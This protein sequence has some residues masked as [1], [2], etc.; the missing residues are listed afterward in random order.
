MRTLSAAVLCLV[1]LALSAQP[2]LILTNGK[3]FDNPNAQAIA[4]TG[5]TITAVGTNAEIQALATPATRTIDVKGRLVI[6]GINDAHTHP[7]TY[8][9]SFVANSNMEATWAQV[10]AAISSAADETPAELWITATAGPS[11]ITDAHITNQT[12]DKLAPGRK[13]FVGSWTGHGAILSSAALTALGIEAGV[14]NPQG[15]AFGRDAQ[16]KLNGRVTEYANY[17]ID[18]RFADLASDEEMIAGIRA[19]SDEAIRYGV[20]SVQAM[21]MASNAR[22]AKLLRT[23]NVPLRVRLIT[24]PMMDETRPTV[25]RG[26]AVKFILDGTPV[27]RGAALRTAQYPDSTRGSENF[28][29]LAPFVKL[30]ADNDAQLLFHTAGDKTVASALRA[31]QNTTLKRPRLEH[32]DGLQPDLFPLA[33]KSGAVV[34]INP[35]HFPA[36]GTYPAGK[37][38]LAKSLADAKIPL[39]IGSDGPMNPGLNIMLAS[40]RP[41]TPDE[42]L[43]REQV[44]RAY[45]SGSAFAENMETK[46]GKIAPGMLADIAVLSQDILDVQPEMLPETRSVLT[47]IDGK[48]VWEER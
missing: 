19:F 33:Q 46:K 14:K 40:A 41:D 20:T 36:R 3:I 2:T 18:R 32:G 17:A 25:E 37:Y 7:G 47:I 22:F 39:A 45:T 5:N 10:A 31:F 28:A 43:T 23:A 12:L 24:F 16:G 35:T 21:P 11:I 42:S 29:D 26:G 34:V 8:T 9:P 44:L 15:G 48:V 38:M 1:S 30:A 13:V 4:I 6:P 27:E